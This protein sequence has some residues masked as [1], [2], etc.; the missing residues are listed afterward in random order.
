[1][2]MDYGG[3]NTTAQINL[4]SYGYI[5]IFEEGSF[6]F[7][8]VT[9]QDVRMDELE[10]KIFIFSAASL[11][12]SLHHLLMLGIQK[13]VETWHGRAIQLEDHV[14]MMDADIFK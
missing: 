4:T 11:T 13:S 7:N 3:G 2:V 14:S 6:I 1:M 5:E 8:M 12:S 9:H 10:P